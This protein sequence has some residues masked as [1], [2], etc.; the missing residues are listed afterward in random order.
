MKAITLFLLLAAIVGASEVTVSTSEEMSDSGK[1]SFRMDTHKRDGELRLRVIFRDTNDDGILEQHLIY[2]C[3]GKEV[4]A[5]Y[6]RNSADSNL[7]S[8]FTTGPTSGIEVTFQVA[9]AD[10]RLKS[11]IA[12]GTG[13]LEAA[14]LEN[15]A[16]RL[17]TDDELVQIQKGIDAWK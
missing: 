4:V 11:I 13:F 17:A 9:N 2:L 10:G 14:M 6:I 7:P 3:R 12:H 8:S 5:S 15:G 16:W 1:V